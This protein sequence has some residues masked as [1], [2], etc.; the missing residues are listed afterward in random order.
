MAESRPTFDEWR[1]LYQAAIR[2]KEITPWEWMTET[3][4]FGVQNPETDEIGFVSVMGTLGEH[5][6]VAVYLGDEGLYSF[7][8]FQQIAVSAPP[9]ALLGLPHLQASFE[10]RSELSQKDRDVIKELGLKFR[11]RQAWPMFRSYRPGFFPWY[12]EAAEARFLT[13]ALEQA[14]EVAR[15]CEEDPAMLDTGDEESYLVRVPRGKEGALVWEDRVVTVPPVEPEPIPI[16]MDVEVLEEVKRLPRSRYTLE[17]DF[18]MVP[19]R[20]GERGARPYFPHMLLVVEADSGM[21]LGSELLTPESGLEAMW[22]LVPVTLVYQFARLGI[23]PRLL[24]VRSPLLAQL[25]QPLV[26]ELGI[27]VKSTPIL[28]SLEQAKEFLLQRFV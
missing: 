28:R 3:D 8:G 26:E 20:I 1:K 11:G 23:V 7:W 10:N 9:E 13:H 4:V 18:F 15:R 6:A 22:G 25:L 2:V 16:A 24:R 21:V 5:L 17:M 19:V 12:L 27:K 14:V